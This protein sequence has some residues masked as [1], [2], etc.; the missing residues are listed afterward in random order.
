MKKSISLDVDK[1]LGYGNLLYCCKKY[2]PVHVDELEPNDHWDCLYCNK[3]LLLKSSAGE[4]F[5]IGECVD[6]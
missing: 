2:Q 1:S 3:P 4:L 6:I 5:L